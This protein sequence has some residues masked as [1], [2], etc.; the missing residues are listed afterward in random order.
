ME[1]DLYGWMLAGKLTLSILIWRITMASRNLNGREIPT[2][3]HTE[4]GHAF[5]SS[6][7]RRSNNYFKDCL[8]GCKLK[9]PREHDRRM[10]EERK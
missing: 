5:K 10:N 4:T 6:H 1:G 8:H 2:A 7:V 9:I 3:H